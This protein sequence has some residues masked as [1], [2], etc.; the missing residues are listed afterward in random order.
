MSLPHPIPD[1]LVDL[2]ARR[3]RVISEPTRIRLLDHLRDGEQSVNELATRMRASQQNV[4]KHLTVLSDAG[5]VTRRKDG[6]HVHYRIADD[7]ALDLCE[8]VCGSLHQQLQAL[9]AVVRGDLSS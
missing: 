1:E 4:S 6:N 7:G 3:L 2:I 8:Q 5:F 9:A